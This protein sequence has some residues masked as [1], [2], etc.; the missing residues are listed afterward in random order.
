MEKQKKNLT[1]YSITQ[2]QYAKRMRTKHIV[3]NTHTH[4]TQNTTHTHKIKSFC[5]HTRTHNNT[6]KRRTETY[7]CCDCCSAFNKQML[8]LTIVAIII[9]SSAK[10]GESLFTRAVSVIPWSEPHLHRYA[11]V[12]AASEPFRLQRDEDVKNSLSAF[13]YLMFKLKGIWVAPIRFSLTLNYVFN[14]C[15]R[16]GP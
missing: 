14:V 16:S 1:C 15:N 3:S 4:I 9:G 2:H 10:L 8:A 5:A 11:A 6:K 13:Q 7:H 12:L